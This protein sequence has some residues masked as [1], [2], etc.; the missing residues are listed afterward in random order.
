[1]K[2]AKNITEFWIKLVL[3]KKEIE[4][5]FSDFGEALWRGNIWYSSFHQIYE[6]N[7]TQILSQISKS[8]RNPFDFDSEK[9]SDLSEIFDVKKAHDLNMIRC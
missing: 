4:K 9:I 1:M 7:S 3:F 8:M 2:W 5:E 6:T